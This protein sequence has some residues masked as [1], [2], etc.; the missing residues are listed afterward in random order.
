M[1]KIYL[2]GKDSNRFCLVDDVDFEELSKYS[3]YL[4][5]KGYAMRSRKYVN[6]KPDKGQILM[7]RM[8]LDPKE[9]LVTDH[10]NNEK[11]DNRK[12]NLRNITNKDNIRRRGGRTK[13]T[14]VYTRKHKTVTRYQS[15]IRVDGKLI[16]IG[17]HKTQKEAAIAYNKAA[18]KYHGEY[19]YQN[20]I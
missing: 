17:Y 11:L 8:V 20:T 13:L 9:G 15:M 1:K 6:K 2:R 7:H 4:N 16:S 10:I 19:A 3:W 14:G 5:H 18:K 12:Q